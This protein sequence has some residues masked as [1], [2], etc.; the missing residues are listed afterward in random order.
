MI[1]GYAMAPLEISAMAPF[2]KRFVAPPDIGVATL[3]PVAFRQLRVAG[4]EL[5][6]PI[7]RLWRD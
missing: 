7:L 2:L 5:L 6:V 4:R 3:S 1:R